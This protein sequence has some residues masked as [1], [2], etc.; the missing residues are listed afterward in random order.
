MDEDPAPEDE[1]APKTEVVVA[2]KALAVVIVYLPPIASA[3]AVEKANAFG[4][5][6]PFTIA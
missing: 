6:P 2:V 3:K 1:V 5:P 4:L